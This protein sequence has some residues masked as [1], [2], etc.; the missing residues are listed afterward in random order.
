MSLV[1]VRP[2]QIDILGMIFSLTNSSNP[3]TSDNNQ[4]DSSIEVSG[5]Q[6]FVVRGPKLKRKSSKNEASFEKDKR[7]EIKVVK[8]APFLKVCTSIIGLIEQFY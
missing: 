4:Q 5:K 8:S 7:L 2:G 3:P 1:P 6:I